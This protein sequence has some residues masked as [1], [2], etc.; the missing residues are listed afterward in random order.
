MATTEAAEKKPEILE[1]RKSIVVDAPLEKEPEKPS[2][3][4]DYTKVIDRMGNEL[5]DLRK[6]NRELQQMLQQMQAPKEEAPTYSLDENPQE[7]IQQAVGQ[8]IDER[9]GPKLQVL[10]SDLNQRR[11]AAF[12]EKVARTYPDWKETVGDESFA[13]WVK[14][15]PARTQMYMIADQ[16]FD[17]D[18]AVELIKRFRQDQAEAKQSESGAIQAAGMVDGGGDSG[19]AKVFAASEIKHLMETD[20]EAYRRWLS[21]EGM[22]AYRDGRVDQNR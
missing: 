21:S 2:E 13:E 20:P 5:G 17:V 14:A 19:G 22:A 3:A 6:Q 1:P 15:S 4:P 18:S 7:F 9:L 8:A 16:N 10:E 12:D 11:G